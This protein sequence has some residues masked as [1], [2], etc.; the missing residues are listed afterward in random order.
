MKNG[1]PA[2][3]SGFTQVISDEGEEIMKTLYHILICILILLHIHLLFFWE[4]LDWFIFVGV[5]FDPVKCDVVYGFVPHF[6][7]GHYH[8]KFCCH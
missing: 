6:V 7:D 8:I 4:F 2:L 3:P 1:V 5:P